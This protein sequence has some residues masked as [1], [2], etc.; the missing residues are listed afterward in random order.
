MLG[1][2]SKGFPLKTRCGTPTGRCIFPDVDDL[3][4]RSLWAINATDIFI[5]AYGQGQLNFISDEQFSACLW[6]RHVCLGLNSA[7]FLS[8]DESN[9]SHS[10][11]HIIEVFVLPS[12]GAN[13]VERICA[14]EMSG[15]FAELPSQKCASALVDA[16]VLCCWKVMLSAQVST[17][18]PA[19]DFRYNLEGQF[20][21]KFLFL[22]RSI[23][24]IACW[25]FVLTFLSTPELPQ[26][27]KFQT[28]WP[29][30]RNKLRTP[31]AIRI[32]EQPKPNN[33]SMGNK[34]A[35]QYYEK[36]V[37]SAAAVW[38]FFTRYRIIGIAMCKLTLSQQWRWF[39]IVRFCES[40]Q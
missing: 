28:L 13:E 12:Q 25:L 33:P 11:L 34:F 37:S 30:Q 24:L 10:S 29:P 26:W 4:E 5:D 9:F 3:A 21:L 38:S 32:W 14:E 8:K 23:L 36:S 1:M 39:E 7:L 19:G 2:P 40:E 27:H 20:C 31:L 17:S 15:S 22:S 35:K 6:S 18:K 16:N